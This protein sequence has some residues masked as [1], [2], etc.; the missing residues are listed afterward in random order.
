MTKI[1][2]SLVKIRISLLFSSGK[3]T[4]RSSLGNTT[5]VLGKIPKIILIAILAIYCVSV[6]IGMFGALFY[7]LGTV[8]GESGFEWFYFTVAGMISFALSFVGSVF[9]TQT[10]IY[11]ARDNELLLSKPIPVKYILASRMVALFTMNLMYE[12]LVMIPAIAVWA[13]LGNYTTASIIGSI[14]MLVIVPLLSMALSCVVGWLIAIL[15]SKVKRK[16]LVTTVLSMLALAAYLAVY[17]F[18][19]DY[20]EVLLNNGEAI[21]TA[22]K[23]GFYP[24]YAIGIAGSGD[25]AVMLVSLAVSVFFF[26]VVYAVL[27]KTFI[28]ISTAK[29][30][31]VKRKYK[32]KKLR[33]SKTT[34]AL[35]KKE[36]SHFISLPM[37][38]M[39]ASL[40]VV[41][42]VIAAG[43]I[44]V[45]GGTLLGDFAELGFPGGLAELIVITVALYISSL[46]FVSAP[47]ISLEAKTLWLIQSLPIDPSDILLAKAWNHFLV[48]EV[49]VLI[50]G[51]A[52]AVFLPF[53]I[54]VKALVIVIPTV[55]NA[56]CALLGVFINLMFPKFNWINET[57]AIKQGMSSL[58]CML[59]SMGVVGLYLLPYLIWL[60]EYMSVAAYTLVF[61]IL[62]VLAAFIIYSY[63]TGKG[64]VRFEK[65]GQ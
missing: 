11:D 65:L 46:N 22:I 29:T 15:T 3:R 12:A 28:K 43:Y 26:A 50:V 51:A 55:F 2:W 59:G 62:L 6:F 24:A 5:K 40:G 58:I 32:A 7:S 52:V 8:F 19:V 17:S 33:K 49:G 31:S 10:Q 61:S 16:N 35:V 36:F 13:I 1:F 20:V 23:N 27:D 60:V 44:A 56:F 48:S 47:S 38:I 21:A 14:A 45:S 39:N 42:S 9:A 54:A 34:V 18:A 30:G 25:Y 53:S 4:N 37:Y 63:L 57:V 64:R 41:F